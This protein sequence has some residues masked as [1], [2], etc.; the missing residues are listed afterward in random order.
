MGTIHIIEFDSAI[1][2]GLIE[3]FSS[4]GLRVHGYTNCEQ[5]LA[6]EHDHRG[7]FLVVDFDTREIANFKLLQLMQ[8]QNFN[9]PTVVISSHADNAF[10][11]KTLNAGAVD[12]I[13]KP[14]VNEI[15]LARM[16]QYLAEGARS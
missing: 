16:R 3:L 7:G 1:R 6:A 13:E 2:G 4:L 8:E 15:L 14:L 10:K 12:V 11:A 5:F 9:L